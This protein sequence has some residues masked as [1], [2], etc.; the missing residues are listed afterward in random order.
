MVD[1]IPG[2]IC[3]TNLEDVKQLTEIAHDNR[4]ATDYHINESPML[5]Q[6]QLKHLDDNTTYIAKED[7]PKA[8]AL[9][10]WIIKKNQSGYKMMNSVKRL[11]DTKALMHGEVEPWNCRAGQNSVIIRLD[12]SL[13]PRFPLYSA[14][15]DWGKTGDTRFDLKQLNE[16]KKRV[17]DPLLFDSES[18]S[19]LLLRCRPRDQEGA[20]AGRSGLSRGQPAA[21]T[22]NRPYPTVSRRIYRI[23]GP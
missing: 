6:P 7:W 2:L 15:Y 16:M 12:G 3:C 8:D 1:T 4:I 18:Q 5:D 11:Q 9:I 10:D 22:T 20:K 23:E 14:S 17:S 13:A 19:G 21:S